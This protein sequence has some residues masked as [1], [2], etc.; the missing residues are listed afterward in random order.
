M[1]VVEWVWRV[2]LLLHV[3]AVFQAHLFLDF[4]QS[5]VAMIH[6]CLEL[7]SQPCVTIIMHSAMAHHSLLL[8]RR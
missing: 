4:H 1:G 3:E 7:H 6:S 2:S 5:D 8:R